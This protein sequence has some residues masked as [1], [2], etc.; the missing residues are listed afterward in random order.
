M[1]LKKKE[2]QSVGT[3]ILSRRRN[4]IPIEGVTGTKCGAET[5]GKTIQNLTPHGDTSHIQ[6]TNPDI[7]LFENMQLSIRKT[8]YVLINCTLLLY[9]SIDST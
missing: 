6:S 3:L 1:K 2:D 9:S 7:F 4:K 5:E 8:I